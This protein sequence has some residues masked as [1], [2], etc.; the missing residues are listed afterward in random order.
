MSKQRGNDVRSTESIDVELMQSPLYVW[1]SYGVIVQDTHT[2]LA[3]KSCVK[4]TFGVNSVTPAKSL[5]GTCSML[6]LNGSFRFCL[7][8]NVHE[9]TH[10]GT[11]SGDLLEGAAQ[12]GVE[13][14]GGPQP[15]M[16]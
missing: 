2:H 15:F 12:D 13:T 11:H 6:L 3:A 10:I 9:H 7:M 16:L 8:K 5:Q 14:C 4:T 1:E